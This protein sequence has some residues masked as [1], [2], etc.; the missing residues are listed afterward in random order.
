MN[1][2]IVQR[3]EKRKQLK[4]VRRKQIFK[5]LGAGAAVI[6]LII[7][8]LLLFQLR[9][10][11]VNGTDFLTDDEV[12]AYLH[13]QGEDGNT[14]V[15]LLSTKF[16]DYQLPPTV[17]SM[18][19]HMVNPWTVRV[20]VK[21][22]SP[23]GCAQSDDGYVYFDKEG[24]VLGVSDSAREDVS[25]VEGLDVSQARQ[26]EKLDVQDSSVFEYI[27]EIQTILGRSDV[28]PDRIVCDGET[29]TLYFGSIRAEL[30]SGDPQEK[31]AQ[32]PP[33]LEKLKGQSGTL[34]LEHYG[35]LTETIRFEKEETEG[36]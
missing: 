4:T 6:A 26:G 31:A 17:S 12:R 25:V 3:D 2:Q 11:Q 7:S 16:G 23:A 24:T 29:I 15:L 18:K 14:L 35:E 19:F 8:F 28:S 10:I 30:G 34:H 13:E 1:E 9:T 27:V 22:K 20:E 36:Q 33:V 21:E 32:L 5:R